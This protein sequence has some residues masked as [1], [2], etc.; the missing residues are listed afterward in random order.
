[1]D[2]EKR[3][4][5]IV[6]GINFEAVKRLLEVGVDSV[7]VEDKRSFKQLLKLIDDFYELESTMKGSEVE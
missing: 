6:E 5:Q 3:I 7:N 2:R 1:M 4:I